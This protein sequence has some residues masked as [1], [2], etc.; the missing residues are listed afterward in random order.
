MT[1]LTRLLV[2]SLGPWLLGSLTPQL[3][4]SFT[5]WLV[6]SSAPLTPL[7]VG[8]G[9]TARPD[10]WRAVRRCPRIDTQTAH[11]RLLRMH[12][13]RLHLLC[14]RLLQLI[15][16]SSAACVLLMLVLECIC[17]DLSDTWACWGLHS[18]RNPTFDVQYNLVH[19]VH[20]S[21]LI[22]RRC[23]HSII[24]PA[25]LQPFRAAS[26]SQLCSNLSI[27]PLHTQ[28]TQSI[29][30]SQGP[31]GGALRLVAA[32]GPRNRTLGPGARRGGAARRGT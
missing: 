1:S 17:F 25:G 23:D 15:G 21:R 20:A 30:R 4:G 8:P 18:E 10:R 5:R 2:D 14:P 26:R 22:R 3:V 29:A 32:V 6:G 16:Y 11:L 7:A 12:L 19:A 9:R 28:H 24:P 31:A 27:G 13:P